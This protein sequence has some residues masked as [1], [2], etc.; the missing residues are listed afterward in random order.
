MKMMIFNSFI[1][2]D[3]NNFRT[4]IVGGEQHVPSR[5]LVAIQSA[6]TTLSTVLVNNK[7]V[8]L[9]AIGNITRKLGMPAEFRC[10]GKTLSHMF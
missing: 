5:V 9:M 2:V 10:F 8:Y 3:D 1:Q 4:R 7:V 6:S